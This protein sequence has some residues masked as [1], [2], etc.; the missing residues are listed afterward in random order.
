MN[1][2]WL[3]SLSRQLKDHAP[4][5]LSGIAVGGVITTGVLAAKAQKKVEEQER[6]GG[7]PADFAGKVKEHWKTYIPPAL[8]GVATIA[9]VI[10]A[11]QIGMRRNAALLGAYTLADTTF[12]EYKE[13]VAEELGKDKDQKIRDRAAAKA[14]E[15]HP[16]ENSQVI[17][18]GGGEQL[19]RDDLTGRY[20]RSDI[21]RI[22]R[23]ANDVDTQTLQDLYVDHNRFYELLG[24]PSVRVGDALGWN[25]DRRI[26]LVFSSHLAEDGTPCLNV[27]YRQ[28]PVAD[29]GKAF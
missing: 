27:G 2:T 4:E 11:N 13:A 1:Q 28:L 26:D 9:C 23:A 5:I 18:T 7:T 3:N 22:R 24:L 25:V 29:Y 20:F 12:R 21:E 8:S 17:I 16:H 19:C 15:E 10:G 6:I 14:M